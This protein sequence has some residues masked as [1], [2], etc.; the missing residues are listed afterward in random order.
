MPTAFMI[1]RMPASP[2]CLASDSRD[3]LFDQR[4]RNVPKYQVRRRHRHR[5]DEGIEKE[6]QVFHC[7]L[8]SSGIH[9]ADT[10]WLTDASP[11]CCY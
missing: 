9:I 3:V 5:H 4:R 8:Q 10:R 1:G 7:F 2:K 11:P 6:R